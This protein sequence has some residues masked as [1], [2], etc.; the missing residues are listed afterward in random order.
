MVMMVLGI[1]FVIRCS[2][3]ICDRVLDSVQVI[4]WRN[5][6]EVVNLIK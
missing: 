6:G 4:G 5:V 2:K 1:V 3:G